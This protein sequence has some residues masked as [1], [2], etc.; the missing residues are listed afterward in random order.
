MAAPLISVFGA[1]AAP[2]KASGARDSR[3]LRRT[4]DFLEELIVWLLS[5]GPTG[6]ILCQLKASPQRHPLRHQIPVMRLESLSLIERQRAMIFLVYLQTQRRDPFAAAVLL[7][8]GER[9]GADPPPAHLRHRVHLV[10][11]GDTPAEFQAVAVRDYEI[12][13]R[14]AVLAEHPGR[15]VGGV[16]EQGP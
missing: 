4:A 8:Q 6:G 3:A 9:P 7:R 16:G 5:D 15:A 11:D 13:D 2:A 10:D 1:S 14:A 12:S